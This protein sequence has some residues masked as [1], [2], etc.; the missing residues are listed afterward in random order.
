MLHHF[1]E[2]GPS[3]RVKRKGL[4]VRILEALHRSRRLDAIHVIRRCRYLIARQAQVRPAIPAL[5]FQ[6]EESSRNAHENN[7]LPSAPFAGRAGMPGINSPDVTPL[8]PTALAIIAILVL[9]LHV[10]S[11]DML[12][13]PPCAFVDCRARRVKRRALQMRC[14]AELSSATTRL[15]STT[16]AF[17]PVPCSALLHSGASTRSAF[18]GSILCYC[19][20]QALRSP[21]PD[22]EKGRRVEPSSN[23]VWPENHDRTP[24]QR[25]RLDRSRQARPPR[26]SRGQGR[27]AAAAGAGSAADRA[28]G[29]AAAGAPD[30][31]ACLQGRRGP[32]DAV[33]LRR[34]DHAGALSLRPRRELRSR[35]RLAL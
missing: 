24:A 35:R 19:C 33:L 29:R 27:P 6:K 1:V 32:R 14:P 7:T 10:A 3:Q 22:C 4:F 17:S 23:N 16:G 28:V 12:D 30:C 26:R 20:F 31:R 5:E 18:A 21:W 2:V 15:S 11:V 9:V 25:L 13:R 8:S 34:G